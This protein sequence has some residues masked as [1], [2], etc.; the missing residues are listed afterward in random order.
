MKDTKFNIILSSSGF[1]NTNKRS[2]EIDNLFKEIAKDK[3]VLLITNSTRLGSNVQARADVKE[4]FEKCGAK[5]VESIMVDRDNVETILDADVIY[6]MGGNV[7]CL[8]EDLQR[9]NFKKYLTQFLKKGI[10]IG[11]SAGSIVLAKNTKYYF[12]IQKGTKPKY[13]VVED[14]D[15]EGLGLTDKNI[16]PHYNQ[17][18][19][20]IKQKIADYEGLDIDVLNDGEFVVEYY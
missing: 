12:D 1:I 17:L 3:K 6:G 5:I 2:E 14:F 7:A 15:F 11:E 20:V 18:S 4:N 19:D 10:Y 16:F 9:C 13:D 8:L